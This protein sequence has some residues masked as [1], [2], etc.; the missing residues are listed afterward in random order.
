MHG[1]A[2]ATSRLGTA[3]NPCLTG[4]FFTECGKRHNADFEKISMSSDPVPVTWHRPVI[5]MPFS[6][7]NDSATSASLTLTARCVLPRW[8]HGP[9]QGKSAGRDPLWSADARLSGRKVRQHATRRRRAEHRTGRLRGLCGKCPPSNG[10]RRG[11]GHPCGHERSSFPSGHWQSL[12]HGNRP[13]SNCRRLHQRG[14][15]LQHV[16]AGRSARSC[17]RL[18]MAIITVP[19]QMPSRQVTCAPRRRSA[20]RSRRRSSG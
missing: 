19:R 18:P 17:L 11:H 4:T 15:S 9:G 12:T 1:R 6:A 10:I 5:A 8:R 20:P 3:P 14:R 13:M 16:G 2:S 7:T